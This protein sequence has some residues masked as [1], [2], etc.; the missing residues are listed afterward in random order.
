MGGLCALKKELANLKDE[1][2][3]TDTLASG[4]SRLVIERDEATSAYTEVLAQ[5]SR[6]QARIDEVQRFINALPRLQTFRSLRADLLP[7]ATLPDAPS[8]W[9]ADLPG[10]MTRQTRLATQM[11][12]VAETIAGL[13]D[14]LERLVVNASACGLK[15]RIELL[16][17]LRARYITAEKD[18]PDR[19]LRL[20]FAE[21][22]VA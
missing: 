4:Y 7:L 20:G 18:L 17:D 2:D 9:V 14:E 10:R 6:T 16:A 5:R 21:Q 15:S 13:R 11:Q 19:R 1:T 12:T 3:R 8:A 22:T